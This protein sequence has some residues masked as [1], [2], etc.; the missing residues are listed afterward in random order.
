MSEQVEKKFKPYKTYKMAC[1]RKIGRKRRS[2]TKLYFVLKEL[3]LSQ[4]DLAEM[5]DLELA[6]VSLM[7]TGRGGDI[8]LNT[9]KKVCNA[10]Q[11]SLDE[12]FG[13]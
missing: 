7:V 11:K 6:Q 2:R 13:E 3:D 9:A 10:L 8:M 12:V 4:M 1:N 5:A